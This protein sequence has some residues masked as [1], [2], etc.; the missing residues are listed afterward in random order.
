MFTIDSV[1]T[2]VTEEEFLNNLSFLRT[3]VQKNNLDTC[4]GVTEGF[5]QT[6]FGRS[7]RF[8]HFDGAPKIDFFDRRTAYKHNEFW[9]QAFD[10]GKKN[11]IDYQNK[12]ENS[13]L[14]V[15]IAITR[16]AVF[17]SAKEL[18]NKSDDEL[19]NMIKNDILSGLDDAFDSAG[20]L[21][22]IHRASKELAEKHA[23]NAK[24]FSLVDKNFLNTA[25]KKIDDY[26]KG[27]Y[28]R[29]I[30]NGYKTDIIVFPAGE[31]NKTRQTKE[32]IEDI[33]KAADNIAQIDVLLSFAIS[34]PSVK[35]TQSLAL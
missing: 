9:M 17:N 24:D 30:E 31:S 12:Y 3:F 18:K 2:D 11:N 6:K 28:N 14:W 23:F 29:L 19:F 13:G 7:I 20:I 26:A 10:R 5:F 33:R 1:D 15:D 21:E 4:N 25:T 35:S 32:F 16:L 34:A 8:A 27:I 22:S